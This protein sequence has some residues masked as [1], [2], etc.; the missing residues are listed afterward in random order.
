MNRKSVCDNDFSSSDESGDE[1]ESGRKFDDEADGIIQSETLP[2]KSGERYLQVYDAYKKWKSANINALSSSEE[3]NLIV[4]FTELKT[5]N[6]PPTL[7]SIWSMLRTTL[8]TKDEINIKDFLNLK[9]L[10]K[11]NNKGYTPK[12]SLV[13]KWAEIERF[14]NEAPDQSY[15]AAKTI[16]QKG[17]WRSDNVAQLYIEHSKNNRQKIFDGITHASTASCETASSS[18]NYS[19]PSTSKVSNVALK[20]SLMP[21]TS[22]TCTAATRSTASVKVAA[23]PQIDEFDVRWEDFSENFDASEPQKLTGTN[24]IT[25]AD[26][27]SPPPVTTSPRPVSE[28]TATTS[29][30]RFLIVVPQCSPPNHRYLTRLFSPKTEKRTCAR[31]AIVCVAFK[32]IWTQK[33]E[34]RTCARSAIVCVAF[35]LIWT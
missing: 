21:S 25:P 10:L 28:V 31:S 27:R 8:M 3:K 26:S 13:L 20:S 29:D 34:K 12:Q 24:E 18:I 2:K 14:M 17:G 19:M 22:T 32:L 30:P 4:Y 35:K 16:K 11:N 1:Y 23:D 9:A 5:K 33:T 7:W 6:K 15:L